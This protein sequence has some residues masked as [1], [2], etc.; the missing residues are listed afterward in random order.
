M[1]IRNKTGSIGEIKLR[2]KKTKKKNNKHNY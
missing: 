2:K 1:N